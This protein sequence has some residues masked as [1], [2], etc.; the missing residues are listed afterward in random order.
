MYEGLP[1]QWNVYVYVCTYR[2]G[3]MRCSKQGYHATSFSWH[4]LVLRLNLRPG[5]FFIAKLSRVLATI[6]AINN[7]NSDYY[8]FLPGLIYSEQ[9]I[10]IGMKIACQGKFYELLTFAYF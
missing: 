5:E 1:D 10:P 7:T 3:R 9:N 8:G 4:I 6:I 2:P